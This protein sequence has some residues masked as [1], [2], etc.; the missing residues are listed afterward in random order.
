MNNN[1]L[2]SINSERI[3]MKMKVGE[4]EYIKSELSHSSTNNVL[5]WKSIDPSIVQVNPNSGLLYACGIGN[6]TVFATGIDEKTIKIICTIEVEA[7][8]FSVKIQTKLKQSTMSY[9][10][11]CGNSCEE[12][13]AL[14][15]SGSVFEYSALGDQVTLEKDYSLKNGT[16]NYYSELFRSKLIEMNYIHAS[17]TPEQNQAW[18]VLRLRDIISLVGLINFKNITETAKNIV[19]EILI[20]NFIDL[21]EDEIVAT[22]SGLYE[23][24]SVEEEAVTYFNAF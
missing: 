10:P 15:Y 20:E 3:K 21:G 19:K 1:I 14:G 17:L 4:W 23:W 5:I 22:I 9:I 13:L 8:E 24:Y 18:L 7:N 6:T 16:R 11:P 2:N 12:I